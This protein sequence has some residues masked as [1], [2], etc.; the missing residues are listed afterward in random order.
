M[1]PVVYEETPFADYLRGELPPQPRPPS[2]S[3][4][5]L[6]F[7]KMGEMSLSRTGRLARQPQNQ[8]HPPVDPALH[9]PPVHLPSLPLVDHW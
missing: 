7:Y 3:P 8:N 9:H 1:E 4:R 6:T 2:Y 5:W